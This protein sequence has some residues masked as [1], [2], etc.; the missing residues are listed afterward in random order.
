MTH[1]IFEIEQLKVCLNK[2]IESHAGVHAIEVARMSLAML[3]IEQA[4]SYSSSS[5]SLNSDGA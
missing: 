4:R 2:M 3:L 1:E 5:S